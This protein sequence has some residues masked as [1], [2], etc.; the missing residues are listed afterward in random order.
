MNIPQ[1]EWE[2]GRS[3][4]VEHY[5]AKVRVVSSNLIARSNMPIKAYI[6]LNDSGH[7]A[8]RW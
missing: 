6:Y 3:S 7:T 8:I 2:C 5:L 4:G 1:Y